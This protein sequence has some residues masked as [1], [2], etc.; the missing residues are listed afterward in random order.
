[1]VVD[2]YSEKVKIDGKV[3][4]SSYGNSAM[5]KGE[6]VKILWRWKGEVCPRLGKIS[7]Q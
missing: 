5:H 3:R 1:M 6:C 2:V 4:F 7:A